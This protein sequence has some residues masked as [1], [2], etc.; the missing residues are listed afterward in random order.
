LNVRRAITQAADQLEPYAE[1]AL[2]LVIVLANPHGVIAE[3]SGGN[4]LEAMY[5]DLMVGGQQGLEVEPGRPWFRRVVSVIR[6][7]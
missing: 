6:P 5:G 1:D 4:L 2:P 7:V 3:L